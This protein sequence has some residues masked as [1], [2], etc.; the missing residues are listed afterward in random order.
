MSQ[1]KVF[2]S[3]QSDYCYFLLDRLLELTK[4]N[5]DVKIMPVLGGVIR[6]PERFK[7][8]D[9]L[10]QR[11]FQTDTQR[12]ADFLGL[13]YSYPDPS[14]IQFKP[15][16]LWI[17]EPH[18]PL[19]EYINRLFMGSEMAGKGMA[20]LDKVA[21]RLWDGSMP[22]W[23][24]G[25]H[26]AN[27]LKEAGLDLETILENTPWEIAKSQFEK[28]AQAMLD[29]GHWGVPLMIYRGEAFYGQD[30]FDQLIWRMQQAGEPV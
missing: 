3:L 17:P 21:R 14:P 25:D 8:R 7:D 9:I 20:F 12:T 24:Q 16:S 28:N 22:G 30:R 15:D 13:P 18:Q 10:E 11:Y 29:S 26:L 5:V 4:K 1:V 19:N 2:Y 27:A 23:N 6:L